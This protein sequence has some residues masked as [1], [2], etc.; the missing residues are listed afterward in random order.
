MIVFWLLWRTVRRA[1]RRLVLEA[2]GV[3]L[4]VA[5]LG[6]TL[7]YVD[8]AVHA[9]TTVALRPVVT[10]MQVVAA[11]LDVD[12]A[13]VSTRLAAE[14]DVAR[15]E[16]FAAANVVVDPG[17]GQ[18]YTARL[19]AVDPAYLTDRPW[20]RTVSGDLTRGALLD[21]SLL[22]TPGF[23]DATSISVVLPGDAP[24][25]HL[26]LPVA[27]SID[28]RSATPW[29]AIPY[30]DVQ[31]D[32][33]NVPR[34]LV[35][36]RAT[37]DTKIL[38]T[39][40]AWARAGGLPPFDPTAGEL[41]AASLES[42]VEVDHAAYP[43]DPGRAV[44]WSG[45]LQR[46]LGRD[47]GAP[48][49]VA[50]QAAESLTT[51]REDATN[52]KI[53]FLLLGLPGVLVAG[54]LGLVV[55]STLVASERRESGLLRLRGADSPQI[56][57]L[58][59]GQ[60]VAAALVGV[61]LGLGLAA[62]AVGLATGQL[63][64]RGVPIRGTLTSVGLAVLAGGLTTVVRVLGLRR[65]ARRTEVADERRRA[66]LGWQPLWRRAG[67]DF[68][69][70]AVGLAILAVSNATGGLR[71]GVTEGPAL[72][73]S[74][75][76][77][78]APILLW[79]GVTLLLTRLALVGLATYA[80]PERARPLRSWPGAVWRWLGRRPARMAV[81]LVLAALA[82]GFATLTLGFSATYDAAK[83]A[84]ARAAI[85]SDLRLTPADPRTPLPDLGAAVTATT[86][87]RV[88][89]A[90]LDTD[91]KSILALDMPS[92][93]ATVTSAPVMV[94][95][96]GPAALLSHPDGVLIDVDTAATFEVRP[97]DQLPVS[98]FPDDFES[99]KDLDLTVVGVF[100]SFPPADPPAELVT[101]LAT[102]PRAELVPPDFHL[103]RLGS[104][105]PAATT[106]VAQQ[107]RTSP[108]GRAFAVTTVT[109]RQERGLAA[110]DL[111]GLRRIESTG[112]GLMAALG[113][114]VLTAFGVLERRHEL[115]ILRSIGAD[116][117]QIR[118]GPALEAGVAALGSI[119][120][121]VP[122]GLGVGLLAVRVLGL[123]FLRPPPLLVIPTSGLAGLVVGIG[124]TAA[125]AL[126]LTLSMVSRGRVSA[127]LREN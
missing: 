99:A 45:Q 58:A 15:V 63:A 50:D 74:F 7:L 102:L 29:F 85:G 32:L 98:I 48:V 33:V 93:L 21:Q 77:L 106:A 88:V 10:E 65:A 116:D 95:G 1:P 16:P 53:L 66:E 104:A 121:G 75:Y 3:A 83:D 118:L 87:V 109:A 78:M 107:L 5:I 120:I 97:G 47:A 81:G 22:G 51:S 60:A 111:A 72:A 71:P 2:L 30:G 14:P 19:F 18:A 79:T 25:L 115:A 70:I 101:T 123:F 57:R 91:R 84:D 108:I 110:L 6:A 80:R 35:V 4:P 124:A 41:P 113:L 96:E 117:R 119:V 43:P 34:S 26:R 52:A 100:R 27:G 122:V 56:I 44:L 23:G 24:P 31:G 126:I 67:L 125:A 61:P 103:A 105:D 36:D 76:V 89:P 82:V 40:Q 127:A 112:A 55:A 17:T 39:L 20:L 94:A 114:A 68:V 86:P 92:Y 59:C 11:N 90:K 9:M 12:V 46:R 54:A 28:L 69:A 37:F 49:L 62:A 42:H 8:Q 13:A 73:L 64:G 38:P